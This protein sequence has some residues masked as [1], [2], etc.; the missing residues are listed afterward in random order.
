MR[1][2]ET[3]IGALLIASVA[4]ASAPAQLIDGLQAPVSSDWAGDT[5]GNYFPLNNGFDVTYIGVGA[6]GQEGPDDGLGTWIPGEELKGNTR[7]ASTG[8]FGFKMTGFREQVCFVH[9]VGPPSGNIE[10]P[11]IAFVEFDGRNAHDPDVFTTPV[12]AG[13]VGYPIEPLPATAAPY[14]LSPGAAVSF[15][16]DSPPAS[17]GLDPDW[18]ILLPNNG[19][20][21]P[22]NGGTATLIAA[23]E[24]VELAVPTG[25][26][27]WEVQFELVTSVVSLDDVDGWWHYVR[28]APDNNQYFNM[29]DDELNVWQSQ[30]VGTYQDATGLET[31]GSSVDYCLMLLSKDPTT[32][33]AL[34]PVGHRQSGSYYSTSVPS[35][36]NSGFDVGRGSQMYS[37][38]GFAGYPNADSLTS[39]QDPGNG[40]AGT[41]P[42]LG[43]IAFDNVDY[44]GDGDPVGTPP[45]GGTRL[46]WVTIDWDVSFGIDPALA[47]DAVCFGGE[48]RAPSSIPYSVPSPWPQPL[49]TGLFPLFAF[50]TVN[51]DGDSNWVDPSGLPAGSYQTP[52][53]AGTT[54]FIPF[55]FGSL[56]IGAPLALMY[57]SSGM[58]GSSLTWNPNVARVSGSRQI[59]MLD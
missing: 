44:D 48:V 36:P 50:Q 14:G 10:F 15:L 27:C 46:M 28:S 47:G 42:A 57:G 38:S 52:T 33:A 58:T 41:M 17:T 26:S 4:A 8:D 16:I 34:A 6:G 5:V 49:T 20:A 32:H 29:S 35:N 18:P 25:A 30:T 24:D 12:D 51:R 53:V 45:Q 55:D 54:H 2:H 7:V 59:V 56:C 37:T 3:T 22:N 23:F 19:L 40:P 9:D 43:F 31:F 13:C 21:F 11:N 1:T 39:N